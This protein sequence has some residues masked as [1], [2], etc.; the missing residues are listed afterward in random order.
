[1]LEGD[2]VTAATGNLEAMAVEPRMVDGDG[3]LTPGEKREAALV[4]PL[5][6]GT[7][8]VRAAPGNAAATSVALLIREGL[9]VLA[10]GEPFTL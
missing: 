6:L 2:G 4:A 5:M 3:R 1:M 7:E 9:G 10:G 8:G